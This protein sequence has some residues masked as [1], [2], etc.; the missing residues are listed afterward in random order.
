MRRL[1]AALKSSLPPFLDF[2]FVNFPAQACSSPSSAR[3]FAFIFRAALTYL[4]AYA[5]RGTAIAFSLMPPR[6]AG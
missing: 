1:T 5:H 3:L 6:G 2:L 4:C